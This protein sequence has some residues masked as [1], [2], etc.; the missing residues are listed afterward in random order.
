MQSI[1]HDGGVRKQTQLMDHLCG[2][3]SGMENDI[4]KSKRVANFI[5]PRPAG[6]SRRKIHSTVKRELEMKGILN[7]NRSFS[8]THVEGAK[9]LLAIDVFEKSRGNG[10]YFRTFHFP[11]GSDT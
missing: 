4:P 1:G 9:G 11:G 8:V 2:V 6:L 3:K 10:P 5:R 7:K